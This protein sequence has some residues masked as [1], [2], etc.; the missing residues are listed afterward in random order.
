MATAQSQHL[1]IAAAACSAG[2]GSWEYTA[3]AINNVH[4]NT[5]MGSSWW[6]QKK[7]QG[8]VR[9]SSLQKTACQMLLLAI[10]K[11]IKLAAS[12][13]SLPSHFMLL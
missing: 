3:A 11:D 12:L 6:H 1:P 5:S 8:N 9:C 7:P 2:S 4:T 10:R 13:V